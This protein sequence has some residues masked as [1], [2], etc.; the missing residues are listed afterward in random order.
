MCRAL[1]RMLLRFGIVSN[2]HRREIDGPRHPLD[3]LGRRQGPGEG[4]RAASSSRTSRRSRP[5]RST[6]GC[7]EWGDGASAT[8]IGIPSVVPRARAGAT[9][10]ASPAASTRQLGVDTGRLHLDRKV[11]HRDTLDGLLYS[12]RLEDLRTGDLVWDTV[13]VRR[14]R[15]R[16]RVLRL[17]DGRTATVRM[18]WSRTS[19]STTAG[20]RTGRS[21][22]RSGRSSS[23]GARR[24]ATAL[25]W[26]RQWFDIIEPFADY[27][28]NKSHSY[29]YGFVAYQTAYLKANYPVEYLAALLTIVKTN[30]EKAAVYLAE[31]R[32]MGISVDGARHQP[33]RERLHARWSRPTTAADEPSLSIIFGLS[34]VRNV[35]EGLVAPHRGRARGQRA[36]RRLLRLLPAGR[37][38]GAQQAHDRVA[39]QGRR[40]RLARPPPQGPAHRVRA[41]RRPHGRPPAR[42]RHGRS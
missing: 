30:L 22:P 36:V 23:T 3:A 35:G 31:C 26:A 40:L 38:P 8:N 12:E 11:L 27:A 10:A 24:P 39:D 29:G 9:A 41:D 4:V 33:V 7:G 34:A 1:K 6:A 17:P 21:S 20:R 25:S 42:A 5:P 13:R 14:V 15:R 18:R 19:S 37:H 2:L 28:F 32:T 16:E